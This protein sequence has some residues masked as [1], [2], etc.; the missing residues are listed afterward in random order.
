MGLVCAVHSSAWIHV[1]SAAE[2]TETGHM[3]WQQ[4]Y[5]TARH[6]IVSPADVRAA[7]IPSSSFY[8]RVQREG[9]HSPFPSTYL[10][11]GSSLDARTLI[12]AA[13]ASI[14][15]FAPAAAWSAAFLHGLVTNAPARVQLWVAAP[16]R[17]RAS[18]D[19]EIRRS[20]TIRPEHCVDVDGVLVTNFARTLL[21]LAGSTSLGQ[22]RSFAIDGRHRQQYEAADLVQMAADHP[23]ARGHRNLRS[24]IEDLEGDG[25]DSGFEFAAARRLQDVGLPVTD[26]QLPI[27]TSTVTRL[28]DLAYT[29]VKVGIECVGFAYHGTHEQFEADAMR[30]NQIA[31]VDDWLL[32]RLT[33]R[34]MLTQWDA[35]EQILR[36]TL[37]RRG[38][39]PSI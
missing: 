16:R 13:Q 8:D 26:Q 25:S 3:T 33:W 32:L 30:G 20:H 7:G 19:L 5:N 27:T 34:M 35:F 4:L 21:D 39:R 1:L 37:A 17:P 31:E 36:R 14:G 6:G 23:N 38:Y 12:V 10:L 2:S 9:W 22:L 18:T 28:V 15:G 29:P 11:P 24:V